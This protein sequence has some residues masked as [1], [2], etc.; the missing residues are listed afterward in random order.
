[1]PGIQEPAGDPAS[2][3]AQPDNGDRGHW[4]TFG[5]AAAHMAQSPRAGGSRTAIHA[6][7]RPVAMPSLLAPRSL[8]IIRLPSIRHSARRPFRQPLHANEMHRQMPASALN[9]CVA[10]VR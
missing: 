6:P 1:M 3:P 9:L 7:A 4:P 5:H 8:P 10:A 2:H